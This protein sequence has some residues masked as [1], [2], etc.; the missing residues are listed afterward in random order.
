MN[1]EIIFQ[2]FFKNELITDRKLFE[3]IL[4]RQNEFE[5]PGTFETQVIRNGTFYQTYLVK[6]L[7]DPNFSWYLKNIQ[8]FFLFFIEN[9]RFIDDCD[10][11]WK[12]IFMIEIVRWFY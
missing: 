6:D 7:T 1:L 12:L 2:D 9:G 10:K 4:A 5:L 3:E 11:N 8:I